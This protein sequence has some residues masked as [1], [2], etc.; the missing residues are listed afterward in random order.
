MEMDDEPREEAK[1]PIEK[2]EVRIIK[3]TDET[4]TNLRLP[5]E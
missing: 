4:A 3:Q 5:S 1:A 2:Y